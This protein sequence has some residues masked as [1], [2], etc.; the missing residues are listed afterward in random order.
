MRL[1]LLSSLKIFK[2]F[3]LILNLKILL[4]EIHYFR[5]PFLT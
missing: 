1:L 2:F 3:F 4:K 5:N